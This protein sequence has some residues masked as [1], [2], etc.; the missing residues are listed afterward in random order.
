MPH[1][2]EP[3]TPHYLFQPRA[4]DLSQLGKENS[5]TTLKHP[6]NPIFL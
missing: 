5:V 3:W 2:I 4:V 6:Q 1:E